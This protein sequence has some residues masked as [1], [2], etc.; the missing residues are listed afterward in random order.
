MEIKSSRRHVR[1]IKEIP[2]IS[3]AN[4]RANEGWKVHLG[5]GKILF[6]HRKSTISKEP[7]KLKALKGQ[8]R[9]W[10]HIKSGSLKSK[11]NKMH[12]RRASMDKKAKSIKSKV[13]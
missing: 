6:I 13:K 12:L 11:A 5:R 9:V 3:K 1:S 10:M 7:G 2:C 4:S 8:K